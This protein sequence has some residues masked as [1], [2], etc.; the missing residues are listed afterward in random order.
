MAAPGLFFSRV[1]P[2]EPVNSE[3]IDEHL[4]TFINHMNGGLGIHNFAPNAQLG[5]QFF[6]DKFNV[7]PMSGRMSNSI[8]NGAGGAV[9]VGSVFAT[10]FL[11]GVSYIGNATTVSFDPSGSNAVQV[12]YGA[13]AT[14]GTSSVT[15]QVSLFP[16]P[17]VKLVTIDGSQCLFVSG[18]VPCDTQ[19]VIPFATPLFVQTNFLAANQF[20]QVTAWIAVPHSS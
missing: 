11:V 12:F 7:Y 16:P 5:T 2:N 9:C 8:N 17:S 13:G 3:H 19:V 18:Y 4:G 15:Y 6:L 10:S 20:G 14:S 1:H